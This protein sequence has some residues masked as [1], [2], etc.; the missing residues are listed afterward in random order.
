MLSITSATES[1]PGSEDLKGSG[2]DDAS[3]NTDEIS[4]G[5][6]AYFDIPEIQIP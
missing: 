4:S 1:V 3:M 6:R 2:L 5:R